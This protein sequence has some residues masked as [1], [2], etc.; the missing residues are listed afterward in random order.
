MHVHQT[1]VQGE[2][3]IGLLGMCSDRYAIL[4]KKFPKIEALYAP[5]IK[6]TLYGT[7]L[8][9]LFCS[10]NSNGLL[11]PY[12]ISDE[13]AALLEKKL[14]EHDVDT[15]IGRLKDKST[16]LGNLIACNDKAALVSSM[17]SDIKGVRDVLGVEVIQG[18]IAGHD[19][20]GACCVA[21]NKGFLVH[22]DAGSELLELASIFKVEGLSGSVNFGFPFVKSGLIANSKGYVTGSRTT[23]IELGRIDEALGFMD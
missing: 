23:G 6:T 21:T 18:E 20:V 5:V 1:S 4:S 22:P 3:F 15:T 12:F 2:D 17:I 19:E 10:G 8:I 9:G 11:L 16:A 13:E 14:R 7:N